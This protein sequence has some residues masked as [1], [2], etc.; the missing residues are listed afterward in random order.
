MINTRCLGIDVGID[1]ASTRQFT[2]HRKTK[3]N[4]L[5]KG[6]KHFVLVDDD[7]RLCIMSAGYF[8]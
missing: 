8:H 2:I 7:F 1:Y 5:K 4:F 3:K 6:Q